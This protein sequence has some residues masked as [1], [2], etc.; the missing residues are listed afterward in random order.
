MRTDPGRAMQEAVIA[1][2]TVEERQAVRMR[3]AARA[4]LLAWQQSDTAGPMSPLERAEFLLRRL[5][6]T[7][8]AS[9]LRQVI[10]QLAEAQ[11][12]G[13]WSGF[14]RPAERSRELSD[15]R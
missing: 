8:H 12:R 2:M 13:E 10:D 14:R 11:A 6:P 1:R 15:R 4:R 3:L 7:M 5:Y 9:A